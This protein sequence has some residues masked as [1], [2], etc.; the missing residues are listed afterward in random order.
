MKKNLRT[1]ACVFSFILCFIFSAQRVEAKLIYPF[2]IQDIMEFVKFPDSD[3]GRYDFKKHKDIDK[4]LKKLDAKSLSEPWQMAI[5]DGYN[6]NGTE[7]IF[8]EG[9]RVV[10][11]LKN[12]QINYTYGD[13]NG[14]EE[15]EIELFFD[16]EAAL[17]AF[18]KSAF[19]IG[20]SDFVTG[21]EDFTFEKQYNFGGVGYVIVVRGLTVSFYPNVG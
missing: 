21:D 16:C 3:F 15:R 13:L 4:S 9:T 2:K 18:I 14:E 11:L 17:N 7:F 20:Y 1:L 8:I 5:F 6:E 12:V 10:Y 19:D